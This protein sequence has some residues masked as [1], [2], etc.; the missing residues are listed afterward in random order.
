[1][2]KKIGVYS[3]D[4]G[5]YSPPAYCKEQSL[6]VI[7]INSPESIEKWARVFEI[8]TTDLVAAIKEFGPV[9]RDIRRGFL[10]RK[11]AA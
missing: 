5:G 6:A 4:G 11:E 1:M 10:E 8:S 9:V 7:D 2:S 3:G